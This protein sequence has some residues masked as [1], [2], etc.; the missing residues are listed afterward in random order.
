MHYTLRFDP[1]AS[2]NPHGEE[3]RVRTIRTQNLL[4]RAVSNHE[5][6]AGASVHRDASRPAT[7]T[8]C[9]GDKTVY[10]AVGLVANPDKAV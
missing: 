1:T 5:G 8:Q 7:L 10:D 6:P 9:E 3:A 4:P 2:F